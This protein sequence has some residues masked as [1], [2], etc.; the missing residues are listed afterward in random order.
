MADAN[1]DSSITALDFP[2]LSGDVEKALKDLLKGESDV[3]RPAP[4]NWLTN[5]DLA[6]AEGDRVPSSSQAVQLTQK[7][8]PFDYRAVLNFKDQNPHHSTCVE[9]RKSSICGL[10]LRDESVETKLDELCD[11]SWQ[12]VLEG[13][14]EDRAQTGSGYIEAVRDEGSNKIVAMYHITCVDPRIYVETEMPLDY[15]YQILSSEGGETR[16][17]ARFGDRERLQKHLQMPVR[18]E[19]IHLRRSNSRSRW[20]GWPD[21]LS[22]VP[23]VEIVRMLDQHTFDLY[24]NRGVPEALY[25]FLGAMV[26][27]PDQT[28]IIERLKANVG[29]GNARK[30]TALFMPQR[31]LKVQIEKLGLAQKEDGSAF[32]ELQDALGFRIVTAWRTPPLLAGIQVAGKLGATNELPN[33]LMA[34]QALVIGPEQKAIGSQLWNTLGRELALDRKAFEWKKITEE[35]SPQIMDTV[36]R[37]RDPA[38]GAAGQAR[39][40][41]AGLQS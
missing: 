32:A 14:V 33:A 17:F 11:G 22:A 27:E 37:M 21:W 29:L 39:D 7:G 31:D 9:T 3:V 24:L 35:I 36:A 4:A 40:L 10:G 12:E 16:Y 41:G 30:S 1:G 34:Y 38:A 25:L 19:L 18:S 13:A 5:E 26:S 2:R 8:L 23:S 20:Y 15:H 6:K 28:A